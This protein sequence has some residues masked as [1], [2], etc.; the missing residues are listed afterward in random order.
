MTQQMAAN[1]REGAP[2]DQQAFAAVADAI[3]AL[4]LALVLWDEDLRFVFANRRW[5]EVMHFDREADAPQP[6]DHVS[7]YHDERI[8]SGFYTVPKGMTKQSY[9]AFLV[10]GLQTYDKD[11]PFTLKDGKHLLA[12]VFQTGLGGYLISYRNVT[13]EARAREEAETFR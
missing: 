10:A 3:Q 11:V 7:N 6:G 13:D 2:K 5:Y 1:A 12:S 9:K 8:E 4:D